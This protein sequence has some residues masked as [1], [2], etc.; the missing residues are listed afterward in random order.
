MVHTLYNF[1]EGNSNTHQKLDCYKCVFFFVG[2]SQTTTKSSSGILD[3]LPCFCDHSKRMEADHHR[4]KTFNRTY[5]FFFRF[6]SFFIVRVPRRLHQCLMV[7]RLSE[8]FFVFIIATHLEL[9]ISNEVNI[10]CRRE[11]FRFYCSNYKLMCPFDV[12]DNRMGSPHSYNVLAFRKLRKWNVVC[13]TLQRVGHY[14]AAQ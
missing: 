14:I 11:Y 6:F 9:G 2:P 5:V 7:K 12:F 10:L 4:M 3:D 13:V 1:T 8:M